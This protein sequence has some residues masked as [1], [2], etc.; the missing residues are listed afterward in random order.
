LASWGTFIALLLVGSLAW[1]MVAGRTLPVQAGALRGSYPAQF[2]DTTGDSELLHLSDT[3]GTSAEFIVTQPALEGAATP[4]SVASLLAADRSTDFELY[5]VLSTSQ[6]VV[7]GRTALQQEFAYVDNNG[8]TGAAP[9]VMRGLDYIF[10]EG[11]QPYVVTL[12][13]TED[14]QAEVEPLFAR[15]VNSLSFGS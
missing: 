11:G 8:L 4:Q 15:F 14:E 1:Y 9:E 10:V 12:I 2:T 3:L 6:A 5:K 7:N 13:T